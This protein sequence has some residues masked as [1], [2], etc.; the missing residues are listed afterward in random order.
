[1]VAPGICHVKAR[2]V[3]LIGRS[4]IKNATSAQPNNLACAPRLSPFCLLGEWLGTRLG[5]QKGNEEM[6]NGNEDAMEKVL[7]FKRTYVGIGKGRKRK[8]PRPQL[9]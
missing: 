6:G 1:M 7:N 2:L 9:F 8:M 5:L 3:Y 4:G